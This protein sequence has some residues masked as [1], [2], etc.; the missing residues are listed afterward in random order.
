MRPCPLCGSPTPGDTL[1]AAFNHR[2][3]TREGGACPACVQESLLRLLLARGDEALHQA[4]QAAW[5][6]DAE[7][8]FGALPAPLRLHADPR[9]AGRGV[10]LALVDSGFYPHPDL[11]AR[12]NR[13][14][15]WSDQGRDPG[16][17]LRFSAG[18]EPRWPEWNAARDHQWHGTMTSVVAAGDGASSDG[19]YRGLAGEADLVLLPV[20]DGAGHITNASVVRALDW[21][22]THRAEF[23]IRVVNLSLGGDPVEPLAGNPVDRAVRRLTEAGIVVVAAAGNSGA[24]HLLPPATAPDALTIGGLDDQSL[25][26]HT[27]A[28]LWHSNYGETAEGAWKPELVAPSIWVA[29]PVLPGT[30]VSH[31][32][33]ELFARRRAG[34]RGVDARLAELKAITPH[35]QHVD[36]T[37][38]AA[39]LVASAVACLLEANPGLTPALVRDTLVATAQPVPGASRERQGAG[40]LDPGRAVARALAERHGDA[41]VAG[42]VVEGGRVRF[43]LHDHDATSLA[44]FGSWDGW[45]TPVPLR[46]TEPGVW[47]SELVGIVAGRHAYKLQR[48]G[49]RWLDDPA[50]PV[51]RPDGFGGLNSVVEVGAG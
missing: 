19:L 6:L 48:N 31:E 14:R 18:E 26:D 29:A 42:P 21:I 41:G 1:A 30:P 37:S 34:D 7:A 25:L 33:A 51:K 17:V 4:V 10:T 39:P 11:V 16:T 38:F 45:T 44:V 36:G 46:A 28:R 24:R 12:R 50:N 20:R 5:P 40:V 47:Q 35:Y 13:I 3:W 43:Q 49:S 8:A 2:D 15:A 32:L 22:H 9:F 27:A 23:G